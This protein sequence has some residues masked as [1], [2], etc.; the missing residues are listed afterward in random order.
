M[1]METLAPA[2]Y[3]FAHLPGT[4][5]VPPEQLQELAPKF[6]PDKNAWHRHTSTN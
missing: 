4:I 5:D 6:A 2:N 3:E 1:L